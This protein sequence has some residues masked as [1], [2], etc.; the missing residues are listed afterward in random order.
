[1]NWLERGCV[2]VAPAFQR[3][4]AKS[5]LVSSMLRQGHL[6]H[7]A[8]VHLLGAQQ[9]TA[10]PLLEELSATERKNH[11]V[12]EEFT[13]TSSAYRFRP[14]LLQP[15]AAVASATFGTVLRTLS[16]TISQSYAAGVKLA[17]ADYYNDQIREIYA[18]LDNAPE[19]AP[20]K[21]LF[22]SLRDAELDDIERIFPSIE[23]A[24]ADQTV[25]YARQAT[26]L[27][28]SPAQSV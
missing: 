11:A 12:L 28:L 19:A 17:I 8:S 7:A 27:V 6:S 20:L 5:C 18:E 9:S 21:E 4:A 25:Q 14:S 3:P 23:D 1:M 22:K 2:R 10:T 16:P 26:M 15:F 24:K 13:K